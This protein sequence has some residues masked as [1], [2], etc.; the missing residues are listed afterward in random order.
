MA[1][2]LQFPKLGVSACIWHQGR[3]L[4][5]QRAKA[6]LAGIW[7]LPGGHVE[8]GE[9]V[10]EAALRELHEET[11]IKARLD[12]LV[13]IYDLIRRDQGGLIEVHYAIACF[14][15]PWTDGVAKA[16]SDALSIEWADPDLLADRDFTPGVAE[17]IARAREL[18]TI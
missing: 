11:G 5:V 15:G 8:A 2:P 14:A 6:P 9:R 3:V 13:G 1:R 18:M 7:S 12:H 10:K 16:A 17:A 4:I